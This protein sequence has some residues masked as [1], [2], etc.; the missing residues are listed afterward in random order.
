MKNTL[1][2]LESANGR[3][4]KLEHSCLIAEDPKALA[5]GR[6]ANA[7]SKGSWIAESLG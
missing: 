7:I 6:K 4:N 5:I 2:N 3:L 1:P